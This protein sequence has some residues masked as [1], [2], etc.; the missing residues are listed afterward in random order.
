MSN[1]CYLFCVLALSSLACNGP[2]QHRAALGV[3]IDHYGGLPCKLESVTP[4][5]AVEVEVFQ[6]SGPLLGDDMDRTTLSMVAK[7][8]AVAVVLCSGGS[9]HRVTFA[10]AVKLSIENPHRDDI[11]VG[12]RASFELV[13]RDAKGRK[14]EIKNIDADELMW[15]VDGP[16]EEP[17]HDA[18]PIFSSYG[19]TRAIVLSG[20]GV[21]KVGATWRGMSAQTELDIK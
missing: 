21:V 14:L 8:P 9:K 4:K 15:T 5:E 10:K 3:A 1:A 2:Q 20:T 7:A 17:P 11:A 16:F 12:K 19:N 13:A 18:H 6:A